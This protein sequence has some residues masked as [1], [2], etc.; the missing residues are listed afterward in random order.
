MIYCPYTDEE[1]DE[2]ETSR[3][4]IIP[5]SLGGVN[6][7]TV[8]VCKTFNSEVGSKIDGALANDFFVLS[9]RSWLGV[10]GHSGR[11]PKLV[12][13][14]TWDLDTGEPL[15]IL[16]DKQSGMKVWLPMTKTYST[17]GRRFRSSLSINRNSSIRFT[18]KV[19]LSA[20]YFLYGD[21]FRSNVSHDEIRFIMNH[22]AMGV[23]NEI[24]ERATKAKTRVVDRFYEDK[25]P[26]VEVYRL[27]CS[28]YDQASVVGFIPCQGDK[29][30]FFVGIL[31]TFVGLLNMPA[32]TAKFP[33]ADQHDLGHVVVLKRSGLIRMSFR[34]AVK[35]LAKELSITITPQ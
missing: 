12:L 15:Q 9:K 35:M 32:D 2:S 28:A 17:D 30:L 11:K 31:G 8:G 25:D 29:M 16:F 18:A 5:L 1:L 20:G 33:I 19:A 3:E 4:H 26:D 7:F 24:R 10:R 13:K 6:D 23:S 21:L 27:L 14:K 22:D 34:D